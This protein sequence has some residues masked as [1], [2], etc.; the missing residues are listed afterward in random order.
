MLIDKFATFA[1]AQ[2]IIGTAAARIPSTTYDATKAGDALAGSEQKLR[3]Q[4][5][6]TVLASGGAANVTFSLETHTADSFTS[7]RTVLWKSAAI[8]KA[9]LVAGYVVA[10]LVIPPGMLRYVNVVAV[11]D[12]H[13]TTAGA[14][15]A[16][17]TPV[18]QHND[19]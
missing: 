14:I 15:D 4:I 12:T 3:I 5:Q 10:D 18:T 19:L 17:V 7:E 6:D 13:D 9:T 1:D 2:S 8:P 11:P 16:F